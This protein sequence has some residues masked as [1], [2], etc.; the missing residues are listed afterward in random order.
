MTTAPIDVEFIE[1]SEPVVE[2]ADSAPKRGRGRPRGQAH[3]NRT[4]PPKPTTPKNIWPAGAGIQASLTTTFEALGMAVGLLNAIDGAAIA[5]GASS[6]S[7]ALVNLA[8][9][10]PKYRKFLTF[11]SVPGNYLP[12]V[13]ALGGIITPIAINHNLFGLL[14]DKVK[15]PDTTIGE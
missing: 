11:S 12:I 9:N 7:A 14:D 15:T 5:N 3:F 2:S 6:L 4:S 13:L 10:E 8:R 1:P